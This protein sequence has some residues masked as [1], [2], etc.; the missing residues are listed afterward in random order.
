[1]EH[2]DS[3]SKLYS[4]YPK[5]ENEERVAKDEQGDMQRSDSNVKEDV[6]E[7]T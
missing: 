4:F 5:K 2:L 7:A 3:I 1:V 6:K